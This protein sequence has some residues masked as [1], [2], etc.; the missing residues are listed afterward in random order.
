MTRQE[1]GVIAFL[2]LGAI[3]G[4]G[5]SYYKKFNPPIN[6]RPDYA[7]EADTEIFDALLIN[8]K[9][10]NINRAEPAELMKLR[11]IGPA[12]AYRIAEYRS[13][14][15][16]FKEREELKKVKGIGPKKFKDIKDCI[17]LE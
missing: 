6:I 9:S 1:K 2:I 17:L 10:V 3:C 15:G 16:P 12:L 8:E 4:L 7:A 11:G 13:K 5:Y 14:N